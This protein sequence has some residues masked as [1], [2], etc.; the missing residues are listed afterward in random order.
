LE[1]IALEYAK[2]GQHTQAQQVAKRLEDKATRT[3]LING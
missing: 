3:Q 1:V 2:A